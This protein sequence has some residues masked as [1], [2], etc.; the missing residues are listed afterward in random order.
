MSLPFLLGRMGMTPGVL[1]ASFS[2]A[3]LFAG[4]T[5]GYW[6]PSVLSSLWQDSARTT[7][8]TANNDPIGAI[9][10]LSGNGNHLVQATADNRPLYKTSGGLSWLESDGVNDFVRKAFTHNQPVDRVIAF[11]QI[12][13]IHGGRLWDGGAAGAG[14]IFQDTEIKAFAGSVVTVM[15]Q[16]IG[17]NHVMTERWAGASSRFAVD[18]GAYVTG[19]AG[20]DN[21]G[22]FTLSDRGDGVGGLQS[23]IRFYGGIAI[24][25][26]LTDAEIAKSRTFFGALAGLTL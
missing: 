5:G 13:S 14:L 12:A 19:N 8:V 21:P 17:V 6:D 1:G 24:S 20:A 18:N 2:P 15:A 9:D 22:G 23:R 26:A 3:T 16:D 4:E 7:P 10:D 11:Q 25:R